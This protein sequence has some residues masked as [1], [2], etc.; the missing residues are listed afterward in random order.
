MSWLASFVS[1]L[2]WALKLAILIRVLLSWIRPNPYNPFVQAIYQITEL[3]M[4]PLRRIIP[5]L[6]MIDITPMVALIILQI[7][8]EIVLSAI[9]SLYF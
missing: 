4:G 3:I 1:L 7:I 5:P 9:R 6:G 2:F 8:Q